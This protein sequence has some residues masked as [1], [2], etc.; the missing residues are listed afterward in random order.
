MGLEGSPCLSGREEPLVEQLQPKRIDRSDLLA[1]PLF[2][3][4]HSYEQTRADNWL[5]EFFDLSWSDL[6]A[7]WQQE[8][9]SVVPGKPDLFSCY[10]FPLPLPHG[11]SALV[12]YEAYP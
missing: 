5:E 1:K 9:P 12:E 3:A 8:L 10:C 7:F 11:C 4:V 6:Q 2:W